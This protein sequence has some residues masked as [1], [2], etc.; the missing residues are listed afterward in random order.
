MS[1]SSIDT[2]AVAIVGMAGRFPGA[3]DVREFWANLLAGVDSITRDREIDAA[4]MRQ[5][6]LRA[7]TVS[8]GG[9]LEDVECFDADFFAVPPAEAAWMDPQH[10]LLL[11][12]AWLALEDAGRPPA[13]IDCPVSV[14]AGTNFNSYLPARLDQL[15]NK[16]E[17]QF[18]QIIMGNERDF[19]T[20][21]VSYKLNLHGESIT[22]QTSCSTSLVAIHLACQSLLSGQ[23]DL[24]LAGGVSIRI[25]Q[26]AS[27]RYEA[28]MIASPDGHC[29]PF[30]HRAAGTVP[31]N[32]VGLVVLKRLD[33]AMADRDHC[34]AVIKGSWINNDGRGK[35]G[36][37][38]PAVEAQAAVV[39]RSLAMAGVGAETIRYIETH[40]TGT[41][42]GDPIEIEALTRAFRHHTSRRRFCA[43]GAVKASIGHLDTAAG[44]AGVIKASLALYHRQIPPAAYFDRPNP[45]IDFE[46]SPFYVN[47]SAE[48]WEEGDEPRRAGVSGFGVGGTNVHIILEEAPARVRPVQPA[49][50]V[51]IITLSA[52]TAAARD[53]AV[54]RLAQHLEG[55]PSIDLRDVAC[56]LNLARTPFV[57]R[58]FA[59]ASTP[60]AL[61]HTLTS[62]ADL[63]AEV[64]HA[65]PSIV[66]M[67]GGQGAQSVGM[68]KALYDAEP[69]FREA[70]DQCFAHADARLGRRMADVMF[71][72]GADA[73][74]ARALLAQPELT[75]PAL[76]GVEYALTR[77]WAAWGVTPDA[78]IGHSYGELVAACVAGVFSVE[79][80]IA[81]AVERGRLMQRMPPGLM[82]AVPLSEAD[83]AP[84]LADDVALA[85]INGD[86]RTVLSG[87]TSAIE[88]VERL[89]GARGVPCRRLDVPYAYHSPLLDPLLDDYM[90]L[91]RRVPRGS[92]R[93]PCVSNRTGA[94]LT[95]ADASDPKYWARQM[96]EP[97]RF[98]AG[99]RHL[100]AQG[101][102]CFVEI[103]PGQKLTSLA[104]LALGKDALVAA[105]LASNDGVDA[106]WY[107]LL[108]AVGQLWLRGVKID[109]RALEQHQNG[110]VV[111]LPGYAFD[112]QR[113]WIEATVR[114][115]APA[116][117]AVES[118]TEATIGVA[119]A[120]IPQAREEIS[121]ETVRVDAAASADA[122]PGVDTRE[123]IAHA[124]TMIWGEVFG[125]PA[126]G[127]HDNFLEL[128]G[129]SLAAIRIQSRLLQA[130]GIDVP[131]EQMLTLPTID[132]L[133][134][135]IAP[136]S[137]PPHEAAAAPALP[138]VEAA[139]D[140]NV[141]VDV[142]LDVRDDRAQPVSFAQEWLWTLH[143]LAPE[144]PAYHLPVAVRLRG[145][146]TP[147]L[148]SRAAG[149]VVRR[150]ETLRTVFTP[151]SQR[152]AAIIR[153]PSSVTLPMVDMSSCDA[154][155]R[156]KATQRVVKSL[157]LRPFE[158]AAEPAWRACVVRLDAEDHVAAFVLHH[159]ISDA[160]SMGLLVSEVAVA[161]LAARDGRKPNLREIPVQ[162]QDFARR[163]RA[164]IDQDGTTLVSY[165]KRQLA[166]VPPLLTLSRRP[167]PVVRAY[168][169]ARHEFSIDAVVTRRLQELA[170][171]EQAT[172]FMVVLAAFQALLYRLTYQE[173]FCV[174]VPTAGRLDPDLEPLIGCFI[175]TL[176]V[177]A[178]LVGDPTVH[179]LL[180]RVRRT[181][182]DA[183]A[184]QALPFGKIVEELRPPRH[185]NYTP[186]FQVLFDFNTTPRTAA[187]ADA[188]MQLE[189]FELPLAT[190]KTDLIVD[191]WHGND[192]ALYGS[193]EYDVAL[194][195]AAQV[196]VM[197]DSYTALLAAIALDPAARVSALPLES[198]AARA[199]RMSGA[200]E[201]ER[202]SRERLL[203]IQASRRTTS[204][205][206]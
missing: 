37:T 176:P 115:T 134:E 70:L 204:R 199:E 77:V 107:A 95:D 114:T 89:L 88:R 28:G 60:E 93:T 152:P 202:A 168:S 92:L 41:P 180:V 8:A 154:A 68:A 73:A 179:D 109:W 66:F 63:S 190:S 62:S 141:D 27:Y 79:D 51:Q 169:G 139:V 83:V 36:F 94:W 117:S 167:R 200:H 197:M 11:E 123:G 120:E 45:A 1:S 64:K 206:A 72:R 177:R 39:S 150:H 50:P 182:F 144:S 194:F 161:Y 106:D 55:H 184:R 20:T 132:A 178:N 155:S 26:R 10:R 24:A 48:E 74:A 102:A 205:T 138:E 170:K 91:V 82:L 189:P 9:V 34:Y 173:D 157:M 158:L 172:L 147:P 76:F 203:A 18:M 185:A 53:A 149:E 7:W 14:Y 22:V 188:T 5:D 29:R 174:G 118:A 111:P 31:G 2:D 198:E 166:D 148:F 103:G 110:W 140:G 112:R 25:P 35:V 85:S 40:G 146:F 52:R 61:R 54:A 116:A 69:V 84:L 122:A 100:R 143:N 108:T 129:D 81:L 3:H 33:E 90:A 23:S 6:G 193:V 30:D 56:T 175:N 38:A 187:P 44:I 191:L 97:V 131:L 67:F 104:R 96:R 137:H 4:S 13:G 196:A 86:D 162:Y 136:A 80:A 43:L 59:V 124:L 142:D 135:A 151:A 46:A 17:I 58:R 119:T 181:M 99:L 159:I 171:R 160:W 16:D 105:S 156:V 192:G 186:I 127:V 47:P 49:R 130:T 98:S 133:A 57:H 195:D 126:I 153:P 128:G 12:C 21:R 163:Q 19:L 15:A 78:V 145:P 183:F 201:R 71:A 75:L 121:R 113:H 101:H 164:S 165:W 32:G 125:R 42:V 65:P 87:P